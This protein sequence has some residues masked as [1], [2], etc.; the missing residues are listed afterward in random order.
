ML[1]ESKKGTDVGECVEYCI[2]HKVFDTICACILT[3]S[4]SK[5]Y[6]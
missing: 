3:V 1:T 2:K 4:A 5:T 6:L